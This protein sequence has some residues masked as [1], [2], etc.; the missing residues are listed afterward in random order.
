M[1]QWQGKR[2]WLVGAS[3]G[4]GAALAQRLSGAG[5]EVIL[6]ARSEDKLAAL[7]DSLPGKARVVTLDVADADSVAEAVKDVGAVDGVV[8]LAGVYWPFGA[9]EWNAEQ[10]AAMADINFTGL[11]RVMGQIV[12][13][14]VARDDGHIVITS[15]LTGFR[16]LPGSI[17]YTAS[18]AATMSLAECMYADLRKTGVK[19]QVVN[20]GFIE[21]QL[22]DKNDFKMPFIM[23]PE[24]AARE[25]FEHMNSDKFKKSFPFAFSLLFRASQFLPDWL[26][27]RIFS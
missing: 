23:S 1:T 14:M 18:K 10:G 6:S 27:F 19:V 9:K 2:Y 4:L 17:G 3:D 11:M 22:T 24:D 21:T 7:A 15:S 12:P 8:Y 13:D 5:A 25:V 20:P 16:G 26:Y